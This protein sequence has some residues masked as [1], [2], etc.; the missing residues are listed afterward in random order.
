MIIFRMSA[1]IRTVPAYYT[2]YSSNSVRIMPK[3]FLS[4]V[5]LSLLVVSPVLGQ[6]SNV[7][8]SARVTTEVAGRNASPKNVILFISDGAGP[9]S[10]TMGRYYAKEILGRALTIDS[11]QVGS[12]RTYSLTGRITDSAASA[13]AYASGQKTYNGA[14]G[15]D[16]LKQ[17]IGTLLEAAERKGMATGLVATSTITHATP[18]SFS[19][20]VANRSDETEIASQQIE[21][22]IE[23]MFGGGIANFVS[24]SDGG[25]RKDDRNLLAEVESR[26]VTVIS[27]PDE[28]RNVTATPVIGLFNGG[29]LDYE[30]DRNPADQPS[31]SEMTRKAIELLSKHPDGFFL[32]VEG[33]RIDH[34]QHGNDA[35]AAVREVIAFDEAVAAALAFARTSGNTLVVSTS[36]HETGGMTIGRDVDGRSVY[37]WNPVALSRVK[38]SAGPIADALEEDSTAFREILSEQAGIDDLSP[39]EEAM[40][41]AALKRGRAGRAVT[42]LISRRSRVGFTTGSHTAADVNLYA[43]GPGRDQFIGNMENIKVNHLI[44][45][46]LGLD[47][48]SVTHSLRQVTGATH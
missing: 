38:R 1:A 8:E 25:S 5:F 27:T 43:F 18:A 17:P 15:V 47:L 7:N 44:A 14:I 20:H 24:E 28:L 11:I 23:V 19:A 46:L 40:I 48:N 13:T 36:D 37:D 32:M 4:L 26:G 3:Q 16:S 34:A 21:Q 9:T 2:N 22:H 30:I 29:Q 45:S 35:A 42:E 6:T 33:S 31:L 41:V 12:V 39:E 10:F